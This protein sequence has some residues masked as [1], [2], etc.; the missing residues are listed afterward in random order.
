MFFK[1]KMTYFDI[2]FD[3]WKPKTHTCLSGGFNETL[4]KLTNCL[5]T[6]PK[7]CGEVWGLYSS[8]YAFIMPNQIQVIQT[9]IKIK[10]PKDHFVQLL[11]YYGEGFIS[12]CN[13]KGSK[14]LDKVS[15]EPISIVMKNT[16]MTPLTINIGTRIG[17]FD[18]L[19]S[20]NGNQIFECFSD[21]EMKNINY[22]CTC[23]LEKI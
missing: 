15:D 1:N 8:N 2:G 11:A 7:R 10:P 3:I 5:G 20:W 4:V 12:T 13:I 6:I 22:I 16:Q 19:K 18:I 23:D 9:G 21:N 14:N 17:S